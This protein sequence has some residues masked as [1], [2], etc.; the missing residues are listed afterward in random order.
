MSDG[1][2]LYLVLL[3]TLGRFNYYQTRKQ[4]STQTDNI[5]LR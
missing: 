1:K 3:G 4:T 2:K 5:T